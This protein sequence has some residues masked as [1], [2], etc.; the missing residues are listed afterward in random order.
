MAEFDLKEPRVYLFFSAD[1][2]G[3]TR[4]KQDAQE[5]LCISSWIENVVF[6]LA[7]SQQMVDF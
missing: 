3:S 2:I 7:L 6:N 4:K 5:E 1:I